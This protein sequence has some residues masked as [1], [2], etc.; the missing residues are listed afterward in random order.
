MKE[1][2]RQFNT[3]IADESHMLKGPKAQ[4][5]MSIKPHL[6]R[7]KHAILITGTPALSRPYELWTQVWPFRNLHPDPS[8]H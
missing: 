5:T 6:E 3:I 7:A 1:K 8:W 4:R 2:M